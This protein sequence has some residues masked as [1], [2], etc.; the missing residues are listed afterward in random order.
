MKGDTMKKTC[1]MC[2]DKP[3]RKLSGWMRDKDGRTID[4]VNAQDV[5]TFCSVRCAANYALLFNDE[6]S[7][8]IHFCPVK[9]DWVHCGDS[10]C[11]DCDKNS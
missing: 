9:G 4:Y 10:E 1:L 5:V 7:D 3:A 8:S 11:R 2:K 6:I